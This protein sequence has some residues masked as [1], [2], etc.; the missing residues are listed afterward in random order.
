MKVDSVLIN[1]YKSFCETNNRLNVGNITTIIGKNESGKSNLLEAIGNIKFDKSLDTQ[2]FNRK[3]KKSKDNVSISLSFDLYDYEK[4]KYNINENTILSINK[5]NQRYISGGLSKYIS[6]DKNYIYKLE[7]IDK[8]MIGFLKNNDSVAEKDK[9]KNIVTKIKNISNE[10]CFNIINDEN[11]IKSIQN[12]YIELYKELISIIKYVKSINNMFPEIINITNSSL[13]SK[14]LRNSIKENNYMLRILLKCIDYDIDFLENYWSTSD[15]S[16]KTNIEDNI[17]EKINI[18]MQVF[19]KYYIQE[20]IILKVALDY[21]SINFLI[22]SNGA[23][24]NFE[25]RSNGLKWYIEMFLQIY[26]NSIRKEI[27]N[28][29]ILLDEPGVFLH[30]NAQEELLKLFEFIVKN[31]NQ[32]IY[33]THSPFMIDNNDLSK[34]RLIA[35]DDNGNTHISNKYYKYP[36]NNLITKDT[37]SPLIIAMGCN[38]N[39]S[40]FIINKDKTFIVTEGVSDYNY[41]MSYIE[42]KGI[43]DNYYIIPSTGASNV[44]NIVSILIGF[45]CNYRVLLDAD[46]SGKDEY[47]KLINKLYC[48]TEHV[49]YVNLIENVDISNPKTIEDMLSLEDREKFNIDIKSETYNNNKVAYSLNVLGNIKNGVER[50]DMNTIKNFDRIFEKFNSK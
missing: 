38:I 12:R 44:N 39:Y 1:N 40:N 46:K 41:I 2:L 28:K 19:N 27:K 14:Y 30:V 13:K 24:I 5:I 23:N 34:I 35:K 42:Q 21:N 17:N 6:N 9:I 29:V 49:V 8:H 48:Q 20:K 37:I 50:F 11:S 33:T 45:G 26:A 36:D 47:D 16:D 43:A 25:E 32:I 10:M 3:N 7:Q 18:V 31:D 22:K 15:V 4:E